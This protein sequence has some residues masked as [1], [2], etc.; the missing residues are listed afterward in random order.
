MQSSVVQR[1]VRAWFA[2]N[3]A[4]NR[5]QILEFELLLGGRS[6]HPF[7]G[8]I[9]VEAQSNYEAADRAHV[10]KF[11]SIQSTMTIK[12]KTSE[13]LSFEMCRNKI[14]YQLT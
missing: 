14:L 5:A 2:D 13:L 7:L 11:S 8:T 3:R 12:W 1:L 10:P 9:A 4:P 6:P